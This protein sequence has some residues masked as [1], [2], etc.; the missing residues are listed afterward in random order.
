MSF[1][2]CSLRRTYYIRRDFLLWA[3]ATLFFT[4]PFAIASQ[5]MESNSKKK[6]FFLFFLEREI[7]IKIAGGKSSRPISRAGTG[8]IRV[9][10]VSRV[11]PRWC[12]ILYI[13]TRVFIIWEIARIDCKGDLFLSLLRAIQICNA[14]ASRERR[15][16]NHIHYYVITFITIDFESGGGPL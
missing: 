3:T 11:Y 12:C 8:L 9:L 2:L 15:C 6:G 4:G 14:H 5:Q 1:L 13:Y 16:N 7:R 10:P